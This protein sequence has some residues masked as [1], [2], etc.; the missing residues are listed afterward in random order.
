MMKITLFNTVLGTAAATVCLLGVTAPQANAGQLHNG[1]NY[2]ID[3]F[4]DGVQNGNTVGASSTYE[5]YG[6]AVKDDTQSNSIF[7]AINANL[8][9]TGANNGGAAD[10]NIGWGD[11]IFNFSGQNAQTAS[12]NGNLF[13][14]RFAGTNDSG[15]GSIGVY[16]NVTLQSVTSTNSGFNNLTHHSNTVSGLGSSASMGD[17]AYNDS[18]FAGQTSG[19]HTVLNSIKTGNFLGGINL[20]SDFTGLGL[21]FG[22]F[23]ATG[24]HTFGFSFDK[25]LM[26]VGEFVAHLF[27]ECAND[28]VALLGEFAVASVPGDGD[29][30]VPEPSS[31]LGLLALGLTFAGSRSRK[32]GQEIAG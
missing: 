5:M 21:D 9:I 2:A 19:T 29:V 26:P 28:G 1:W 22:N 27:A 18:Y 15:V 20:I 13:G 30:S 25:S 8:P 23:S 11:L 6:M 3:S 7:V 24:T 12:A 16:D 4:N 32:K 10:G 14:V 31:M 17:L